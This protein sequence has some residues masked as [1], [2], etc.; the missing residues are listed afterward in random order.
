[1]TQAKYI[2]WPGWVNSSTDRDRHWIG[3]GALVRL[4]GLRWGEYCVARSSE[5]V[6]RLLRYSPSAQILS[7]RYDGFYAKI[8]RETA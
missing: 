8:T 3:V 6:D 1:M 5:E 7:P 4:Y 2:V